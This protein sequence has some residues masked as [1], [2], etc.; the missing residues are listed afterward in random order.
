VDCVIISVTAASVN[1]AVEIV[2]PT[3]VAAASAAVGLT[4]PGGLFQSAASLEQV[5]QIAGVPVTVTEITAAPQVIAQNL[6]LGEIKEV[7][8][9]GA[10]IAIVVAV[11]A[12]CFMCICCSHLIQRERA[13]KPVFK[14]V[15]GSVGAVTLPSATTLS[16]SSAAAFR[17]HKV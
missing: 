4:A 10:V 17:V 6:S 3:P 7:L 2:Y 11:V 5:L 1:I 8:S 15:G 12:A 13:G 14:P 16:S 9:V